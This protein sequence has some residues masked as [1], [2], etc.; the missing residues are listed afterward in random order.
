[1]I[2]AKELRH[3]N[4]IQTPSG[5]VITVQQ[6]L[7]S[8]LIYDSQIKV[9]SEMVPVSRRRGVSDYSSQFIEVVKEADYHDLDPIELTP[10]ILQKCGF[11]NFV[12]EDW[13]F[14]MGNSHI[15]FEFTSDGLRLRHPTPSRVSI[16][17]LHQLIR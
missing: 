7:N 1:M 6:L 14:S 12:R 16:K 10:K 13:I 5:D 2:H 3:G 8:T 9:G 4:K 11:R 15:D 17:Y